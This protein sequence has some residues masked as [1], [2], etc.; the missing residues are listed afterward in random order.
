MYIFLNSQKLIFSKRINPG[1]LPKNENF[2]IDSFF[3]KI[4]LEKVFGDVLYS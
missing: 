1:G 2:E 3:G 4:N